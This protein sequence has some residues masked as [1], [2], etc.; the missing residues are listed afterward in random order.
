MAIP[1]RIPWARPAFGEAEIASAVAA[2][3]SNWLTMGPRV[4]A[5]EQ[6][7]AALAGRRYAVAVSSG[8]A[9]LDLALAALGIGPGDEVIV[10]AMAYIAA[11]NAVSYQGARLVLADVDPKTWTLDPADVVRRITPATRAM[12]S[13]DYGGAPAHHEALTTLAEAHGLA[14]VVDAAESL[15]ACFKQRQTVAYGQVAITSFHMVKIL[16]SIEGGMIF[17]DDQALAERVRLLRNQGEDPQQKY[18][19]LAIGNN[20]RLSDLH[21]AIG[22]AQIPQLEARLTE[23]ARLAARY[24]AHLAHLPIQLP[25]LLPGATSTWFLYSVLVPN[26][27]DVQAALASCG[28]ETRV[29]W[30]LPVHRQPCYQ[31]LVSCSRFPVA[32]HMAA[33]VL[34]LPLYVGMRDDE[35]DEVCA[36][37]EDALRTVL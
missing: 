28:I 10:P 36:A 23:R 1:V 9:A 33:H 21:A 18:C 8:T 27:D 6:Q 35:Q 3:H 2:L 30:P 19:H 26:R 4:A 7:L 20:Y 17:T 29:S 5:F 12:L 11:P 32:E 24:Q 34:S 31:A 15:G 16:T 14:L 13:L 22:L 37:L 25:C